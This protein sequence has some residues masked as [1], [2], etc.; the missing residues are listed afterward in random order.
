MMRDVNIEDIWDGRFY[1]PGDRVRV[2]CHDCDG[3]SD[4]CRNTG[5]SIVLDPLDMYRLTKALHRGFEDM[6]EREI[7]IRMV[8]GMILPNIME[9]DEEHPDRED[10]CPFLDS[11]GRCS[12]HAARPGFCRLFPMG[13]YYLEDG[14]FRYFLQAGECRQTNRYEV[15]LADWLDT[16]DLPRYERFVREWHTFLRQTG[17]ELCV[18]SE[19]VQYRAANYVLH[20]FYVRPY[21]GSRSFY[22]Q[23]EERMREA[24]ETLRGTGLLRGNRKD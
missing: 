17:A 10:G 20:L 13:R 11:A 15:L 23:F 8:D 2:G 21:N 14:S 24:R 7:E 12:I 3:C 22:P 6:I 4:C 18:R 19:E 16:P 5:D 9:H 1:Q